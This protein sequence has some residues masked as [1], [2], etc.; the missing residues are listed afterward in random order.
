M[1]LSRSDWFSTPLLFFEWEEYNIHKDKLIE[2]INNIKVS[3]D[4]ESR[5]N[6][7]GWQSHKKLFNENFMSPIMNFISSSVFESLTE[8]NVDESCSFHITQMWANVNYKHSYH[9]SHQHNGSFLS[10]VFYLKTPTECGNI[11]FEDPRNLWCL[12][13]VRYSKHDMF[14]RM[15]VECTP[16]EGCLILFPSYLS[17]RVGMNHNDDERISVS[18]NV[19]ICI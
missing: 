9:K 15:E 1:M 13:P 17:H 12:L 10:G 8:L 19:E 11:Y 6:V 3:N 5:S 18:F 2:N 16:K 7:N 4:S 14:S